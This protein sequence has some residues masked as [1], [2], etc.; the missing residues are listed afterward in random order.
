MYV[1][2]YT[3]EYGIVK[4][5]YGIFTYALTACDSR[6]SVKSSPP[7]TLDRILEMLTPSPTP[8]ARTPPAVRE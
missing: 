8:L 6:G 4:Y 3:S 2:T 1:V 7:G 5:E